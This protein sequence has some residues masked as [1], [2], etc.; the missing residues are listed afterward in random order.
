MSTGEEATL[1]PV[2]PA[3]R[4]MRAPSLR[5]RVRFLGFVPDAALPALYRG[6]SMLVFPSRGEGFDLP[7]LEAMAC[8]TPV[9]AGEAGSIPEI[10][11]GAALL[12]DPGDPASIASAM[13]RLCAD[14][15]LRARLVAKGLARA[16][17]LRWPACAEATMAVYREATGGSSSL[18]RTLRISQPSTGMRS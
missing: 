9:V 6:A 11:D 4:S 2:D 1:G 3:P 7:P 15:G 13:R 17:Q 5:A 10:A 18:R 12:V 16:A 14:D 8:G